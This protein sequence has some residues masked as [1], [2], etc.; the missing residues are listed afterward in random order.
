MTIITCVE[1][2]R[3]FRRTELMQPQNPPPA[4][5][6]SPIKPLQDPCEV[7]LHAPFH[8]VKDVGNFMEMI[9]PN[10]LDFLFLLENEVEET[11][12]ESYNTDRGDGIGKL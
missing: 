10:G 12:E 4:C 5:N 7:G 6:G 11:N 9:I 8:P 3:V 2:L 1:D